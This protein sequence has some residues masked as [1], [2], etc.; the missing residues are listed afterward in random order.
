MFSKSGHH[1]D[2]F[3]MALIISLALFGLV[4]LSSASSELGKIKFNDSYY[5]LKH[6]AIN[7]LFIGIIG[8]LIAFKINYQAYK[9]FALPLLILSLVL[10]AL[11]FTSLGVKTGGA[12][13]WLKIGPVSFQPAEILKL[14]FVIYLAAWLSNPKNNREK[15]FWSGFI[16]FLVIIG[17]IAS[18]LLLQPAT[19]MVA[20]LIG[21][22]LVVYFLGEAKVKFLL[23]VFGLA[24]LGIGLI[25]YLTPY[26]LERVKTFFSPRSDSLGSSYHINEAQIAIG[27]GGI[28]GVGYGNSRTKTSFL[29]APIDDSIFAVTAEELGFI[30]S[31]SLIAVFA[32]LTIRLFWLA[33]NLR[34]KFGQLILVGFGSVIGIQSIINIGAIS[35][36]FPLTGVPLPFISY[37]GTALAV[38]LTIGGVAL[39]ISKYTKK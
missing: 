11:V 12:T 39:N 8:F 33:K 5:Y 1:P 13:R 15:N 28:T 30:G 10:L 7:G 19:S 27:S 2:Y 36:V 14:T 16:P 35:G 9:R 17:V 22:A 29:P 25:I 32:A 34:D 6:Q 37:G 20:I 18:L 38:F 3:L 24:I 31:G 23:A 26:R 4:M 21:T